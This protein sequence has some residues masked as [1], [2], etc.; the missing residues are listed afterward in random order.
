MC[1][2]FD[3]YR[4]DKVKQAWGRFW[5]GTLSRPI[6]SIYLYNKPSSRRE[7]E[8]QDL[9]F[10]AHYD[11]S[12]RPD[13]IVDRWDY[14]LSRMDF[15]GDAF[16][17]VFP[18]FGPGVVAEFL[19]AISANRKDTVWFHPEKNLT[20]DELNFEINLEH[21]NLRRIS[22]II[23]AAM[24]R[25]E[26][27][28]QICMPD[29]GGNLDI[30]STFLPGEKLLL[31][32]YDNPERTKELIIRIDEIWKIYYDFFNNCLRPVNPGYSEWARM[33]CGQPYYMLQCDFSY[34]I[35]P[36][37]FD[38]FVRPTLERETNFLAHSFYHLDGP[39]QLPHLDLVLS[40]E[41]L[42][43]IQ[44][45]PGPVEESLE[46]FTDIYQKVLN[47]GKRIQIIDC[48]SIQ[49]L[50]KIFEKLDTLK[51]VQAM[52]TMPYEQ[53]DEAVKWLEHNGVDP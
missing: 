22:E 38:E 29:L 51:G 18:N 14:N 47:A 17:N 7:P 32:L 3:Q 5:D 12:I 35:S 8:I 26:G 34:M 24:N 25:W 53:K 19:G 33:F 4:W 43:G 46:N 40:L 16:P 13:Q 37:M 28:V 39:G 6:I 45:V 42:D 30:L 27:Q 15:L 50:D 44:W 41:K 31:E 20:I 1:I 49:M 48:K 9:D 2:N 23:T 11:S 52:L 10:T 36:A 21:P